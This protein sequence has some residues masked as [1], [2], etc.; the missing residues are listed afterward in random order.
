MG[1]QSRA[2]NDDA[3]EKSAEERKGGLDCD[4]IYIHKTDDMSPRSVLVADS[5]GH[6]LHR[7]VQSS[8]TQTQQKANFSTQRQ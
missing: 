3:M 8:A 7:S 4:D 6:E 2:V 1:L 5:S